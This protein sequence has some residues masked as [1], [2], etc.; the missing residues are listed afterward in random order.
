MPCFKYSRNPAICRGEKDGRYKAHRKLT[1][2]EVLKRDKWE[3]T[4]LRAG[5]LLG[6]DRTA[7]QAQAAAANVKASNPGDDARAR[8]SSSEKKRRAEKGGKGKGGKGGK[9]KDK[10]CETFSETG[11]CARGQEC[12]FAK[13]T[14]GHP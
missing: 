14:P 7:K 2:A 10:L 12:W 5:K 4:T 8:S 11:Q 9:G 13:T 3:E 1:D 6:Y